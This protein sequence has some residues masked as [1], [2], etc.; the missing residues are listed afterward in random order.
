MVV[1]KNRGVRDN[2]KKER[3]AVGRERGRERER[4]EGGM[5]ECAKGRKE[6][7]SEGR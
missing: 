4:S 1:V 3:S 2:K 5:S 7:R 6:G